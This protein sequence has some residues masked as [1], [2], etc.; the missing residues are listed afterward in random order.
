M[1]VTILLLAGLLTPVAYGFGS[2]THLGYNV[3]VQFN[4]FLPVMGGNEGEVKIHMDVSVTG[5]PAVDGK[6][7]ATSEIQMFEVTFNGAKLPLGKDN[8]TEYF[9]KTNITLDPTGKI[10]SS[11]A[12]DKKLP[13]KL[14]GLDVK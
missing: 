6:L 8:V 1:P 12:P 4:G 11:D 10:V 5:H 3:D 13:V 9:P 2:D 7:K 14:P